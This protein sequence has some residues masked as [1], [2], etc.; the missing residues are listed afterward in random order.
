MTYLKAQPHGPIEAL[1]ADIYL[2]HG[3]FTLKPGVKISRN[4][5][6]LNNGGELTLVNPVRM[7]EQ[8]LAELDQLGTVTNLVRLGAYHGVDDAF[9]RNRYSCDYWAQDG[10]SVYPKLTP[11]RII[12][13]G[14]S[15]PVPGSEFFSFSQGKQ[16][17]AALLLHS[18]RLLLTCDA[19]QYYDRL[20]R[21][22][23][24][25]KLIFIPLGFER[26]LNIGPIW[27]KFMREGGGD[28]KADFRR[29]EQLDFDSVIGAH[30]AYMPS[31]A[32]KALTAQIRKYFRR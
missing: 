19:L 4:M 6:I 10:H 3:S 23:W 11:T 26:G 29:L 16:P 14:T 18:Q 22:S 8:G 9:Y 2:L 17:E 1:A 20:T 15:G 21:F 27:L 13:D 5:V 30:G 7:N 31:G 24:L 25:A 28:L 12:E 32:K